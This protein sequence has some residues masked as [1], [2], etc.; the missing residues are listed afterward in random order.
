MRQNGAWRITHDVVYMILFAQ[1][2][3]PKRFLM[4]PC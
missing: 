2:P 3:L 4:L 1:F